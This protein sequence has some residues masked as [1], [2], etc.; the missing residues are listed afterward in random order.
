MKIIQTEVYRLYELDEKAQNRAYE[1]WLKSIRV[2]YIQEDMEYLI[3]NL[4]EYGYSVKSWGYNK[5]SYSLDLGTYG[6]DT[7]QSRLVDIEGLS[8][9]KKAMSLFYKFDLCPKIYRK[10]RRARWGFEPEVVRF[11]NILCWKNRRGNNW[12]MQDFCHNLKRLIDRKN[13]NL[14]LFVYIAESLSET[15]EVAQKAY[16]RASSRESFL[17]DT[18]NNLYFKNGRFWGIGY[19]D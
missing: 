17:R 15:L 7:H 1:D 4:E 14:C 2:G 16:I 6:L 19:D 12:L 10:P 11:S 5:I 3:D 9:M 13:L 8:A 18:K